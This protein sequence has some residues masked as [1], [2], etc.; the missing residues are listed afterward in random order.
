MTKLTNLT[1]SEYVLM[2]IVWERGESTAREIHTDSLKDKERHY[3]TIRTILDIMVE[4]GFLKK[5]KLGLCW[6]YS[7]KISKQSITKTAIERLMDDVLEDS[8]S[9]LFQHLIKNREKYDIKIDEL[10]QLLDD[11]D[12]DEE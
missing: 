1:D 4:K 9:P 7:S 6:F 3:S 2:K 12:D 8:I 10:K 5:K 11:M